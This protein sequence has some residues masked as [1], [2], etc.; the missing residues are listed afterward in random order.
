[1]SFMKS[2]TGKTNFWHTTE[3]AQTEATCRRE[4]MQDDIEEKTFHHVRKASERG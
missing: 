3:H 4:V 1:M 2:W